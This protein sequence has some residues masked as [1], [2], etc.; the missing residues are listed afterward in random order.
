[1]SNKSSKT[2]TEQKTEENELELLVG[3][4]Q[5]G[6]SDAAVQ[7]CNDYLRM[8][9]GRSISELSNNYSQLVTFQRGY[10]PPSDSY[11]TLRKWSSLYHWSERATVYDAAYEQRKNAER[12]AVLNYGLA[13]EHERIRELYKLA[14]FLRGQLYERSED[15]VFHNVWVPDVKSVGSGEFTERV[16]IE[17][18]NA[19]LIEQYRK[20]LE[21]IAKETGG[22]VQKT[23]ITTAGEP[24]AAPVVYLPAVDHD[25]D[26]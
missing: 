12:E 20:V 25:A 15:G 6:E 23:D 8:G 7:A 19:P 24:L 22:R 14:D 21:D 16:D 3:Q 9:S 13:L 5:N 17:R 10:A 2:K 1:M 11:G 18:F 26:G 4:R